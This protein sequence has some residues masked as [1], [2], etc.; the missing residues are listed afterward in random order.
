MAQ[1]PPALST[2]QV[3]PQDDVYTALLVIAAGL[4]LVG[5]IYLAVRSQQLFGT[6]WPASGG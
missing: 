5:V 6:V 3:A 2:P 4:L 1:K